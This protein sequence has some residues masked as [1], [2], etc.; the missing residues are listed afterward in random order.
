MQEAPNGKKKIVAVAS[1]T[2]SATEQNWSTTE[3]EAF[4]IKW[5]TKKFDYFLNTYWAR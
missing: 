4:A 3:R 5:G 2:F 1:K